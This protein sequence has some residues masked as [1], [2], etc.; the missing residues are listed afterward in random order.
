[1]LCNP[2]NYRDKKQE[3]KPVKGLKTITHSFE[4]EVKMKK[5]LYKHYFVY[6]PSPAGLG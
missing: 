5:A 3:T 4:T 1:M 2:D 6:K